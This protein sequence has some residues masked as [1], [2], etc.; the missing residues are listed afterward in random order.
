LSNNSPISLQDL[1][2]KLASAQDVIERSYERPELTEADVDTLAGLVIQAEGYS[3]AISLA[4]NS[5][6]NSETA[7]L[8]T[9]V[10]DFLNLVDTELL[11]KLP[12]KD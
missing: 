2:S 7:A 12:M 8:A 4:A 3:A 11:P 6:H 5:P 9:A 10:S 1:V